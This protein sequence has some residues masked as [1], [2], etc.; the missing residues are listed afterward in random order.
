MNSV[1]EY[2][3]SE[4]V[5]TRLD[6]LIDQFGSAKHELDLKLR[7]ISDSPGPEEPPGGPKVS[8]VRPP[9]YSDI[10]QRLDVLYSVFLV[11]EDISRRIRY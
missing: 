9:F 2:S 4:E 5:L 7:F 10:H 3:E 6:R 8:Q 11:L 1:K